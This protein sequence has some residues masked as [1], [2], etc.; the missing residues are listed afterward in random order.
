MVFMGS[1]AAMIS[2]A[3]TDAVARSSGKSV[4]GSHYASGHVTKKGK[5]VQRH[6]QSNPNGS[7]FDNYATKGN[8]N[9]YTGKPGTKNPLP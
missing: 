1:L 7:K 3:S 4:G 2:L 6:M 5:Y 8:V 9:P